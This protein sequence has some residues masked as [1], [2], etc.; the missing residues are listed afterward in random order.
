MRFKAEGA[1]AAPRSER[2]LAILYIGTDA[3]R[4]QWT[5]FITDDSGRKVKVVT[6]RGRFDKV[7][8]FLK[9]RGKPFAICYQASTPHGYMYDQLVQIAQCVLVARPGHRRLIYRARRKN[10]R[11]DAEKLKKL[12]LLEAV[13]TAYVPSIDV[14][15]WR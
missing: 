4:N 2:R 3:H 13:P 14:R 6:F 11:I 10:D 15:A 9:T 1:S 7:I 12:L 5:F 8:E